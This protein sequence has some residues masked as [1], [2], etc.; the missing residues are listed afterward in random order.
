MIDMINSMH[1]YG[2][3]IIFITARKEACWNETYK[4]LRESFYFPFDL[5]MRKN[6]D[7]REDWVI[8]EEYLLKIL[9][10][11]DVKLCIDDNM[12]NLT[13]FYKHGIKSLLAFL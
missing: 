11:Y 2:Y 7:L 6:N 3:G 1:D 8:K 9:E 12:D 10:E 4:F 5:Y 13:M